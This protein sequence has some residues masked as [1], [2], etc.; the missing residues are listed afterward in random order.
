MLGYSLLYKIL[1]IIG[2][3]IYISGFIL[4][5]LFKLKSLRESGKY[6]QNIK[7]NKDT[8]N[9]KQKNL[10]PAKRLGQ[11]RGIAEGLFWILDLLVL[12][13]V[14]E[15][16]FIFDQ[17]L[18]IFAPK[19]LPNILTFITLGILTIGTT[20]SAFAGKALKEHFIFPEKKVR[21]DW[22]L[23]TVGIYAKIRHPFY[24]FMILAYIA[25][26]LL[27]AFYP[28]FFFTPLLAF[29]QY[30]TAKAEEKA[31][32]KYFGEKF[33]EYKNSTRMFF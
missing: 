2:A 30:K 24:S 20:M 32:E 27:L 33:R 11:I 5:N 1:V 21:D 28:L 16:L 26:P 25:V 3:I 15:I 8:E 23:C 7:S 6:E 12:I 17:A 18:F 29:I 4:P 10:I 9:N 22:E 31:M 19:D 13:H 14:L